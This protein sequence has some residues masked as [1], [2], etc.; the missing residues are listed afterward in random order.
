MCASIGQGKG[1]TQP[2]R[3]A[4]YANNAGKSHYGLQ[5]MGYVRYRRK[6]LKWLVMHTCGEDDSVLLVKQQT[7]LEGQRMRRRVT[8]CVRVASF[9]RAY[10]A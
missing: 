7:V 6:W 9:G 1:E 4:G 2:L 8:A 5:G 3:L 10:R